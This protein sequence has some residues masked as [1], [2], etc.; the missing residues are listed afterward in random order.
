MS[1]RRG[2]TLVEIILAIAILGII[3]VSFL[4]ILSSH[5]VFL[6]K[7]K[8]ISQDVFLAQRDME[9]EIDV[10]KEKIRK[11][12]LILKEKNIFAELGGVKVKYYEVEKTHNNKV[13]YTLV[14][15]V[16]PEIIEPIELKNIGI[17]LKQGIEQVFYG[18]GTGGFSVVGNFENDNLYKWDHLLNVVEW[19]VSKEDY[20]T[21]LP[22][23]PDF[24]LNEDILNDSYYYPLFPRDYELVSNETINNFGSHERTF[25]LSLL[26]KYKGRHIIFTATPGAKSG[27]I[28]K[29]SVSSPVFISGLP[30]TQNAVSHFDA[31]FID[32]SARN[33]VD[34][35]N[36][37]KWLDISSIYGRSEPNEAAT[38]I[39]KRPELMKMEMDTGFKWQHVR[40]S[41]DQYLEI[42]NQNTSNNDIYIFAVVRNRVE[43]AESV[44]LKNG[45]YEFNIP[46]EESVN[47]VV[48]K[49]WFIMK[50]SISSQNNDFKLGGPNVDIAEVVI[51]KGGLTSDKIETI[52]NYFKAKYK[53]P[54]VVGDIN[55][56]KPMQININ[57]GEN[58]TLPLFVLAEMSRGYEKYV[59]VSWTG[60]Y[61]VN[62]PGEYHL[63]ATSLT[64]PT[65]KMT[66]T[67]NVIENE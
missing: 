64:D 37:K 25:P 43:N 24:S 60:T 42:K 66:Y 14:S 27:K 48:G 16:K 3:S 34:V 6:N 47:G 50:E 20:T 55:E 4:T 41:D 17:K 35:N 39:N 40:F 30:I 45:G 58:F 54:V 9:V 18:Y 63:E 22:K 31:G 53:S 7:T 8:D 10:V 12:E 65:K 19:Y 44:F 2:F 49:D 21:P 5:F 1:K 51:Y 38:V 32:P 62:N 23:D 67:L 15:N 29:Q 26:D 61:D 59:A 56:L 36:V 28:G 33:E 11:N 57:L 46:K 13:Y 52:E